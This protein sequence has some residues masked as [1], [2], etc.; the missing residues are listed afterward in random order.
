MSKKKSS[1][2]RWDKTYLWHPFTQQ[3]DWEKDDPLI[4]QSA[5]GSYLTD[6]EGR[7]YLDGV[8][9]LWVTVHGHR[10][11]A[12]DRAVKSQLAR[13]A[14]TTFLGLTHEPAILLAK[15]LVR[16]APRGLRRV[17][18]SDN[19][20]TAVEVAL[21]MAYQYG[22]QQTSP[23]RTEFL[24]LKNSYHGDTLGSVS[25]GGIDLFHKA[26]KP[27]LFRAR[28]AISPHCYRCPYRRERG[29]GSS[30]IGNAGG[31]ISAPKP[32]DSRKETGCRWECLRSAEVVFQSRRGR[33]AAAVIE[34]SVQG[35]AG[36][37]VMP[38]GYMKG[39]EALCRREGVPLICDEVA[40]GFGRTGAMF[41]VDHEGVSPDIMCV[42]KSITGGY[43]PL[44]ATL[45]TERIYQAFLGRYEEFKTFYHGHTYTAN[46]LACA[47]A[48][49]NLELYRTQRLLRD[50]GRKAGWLAQALDGLRSLP[51]VG[52]VRQIGF[53]AG[54]ELVQ[55]PGTRR[56]FPPAWKIGQKVCLAARERGL[57]LRPLGDV[58]VILPPLG[59]A[60]GDL[61]RLFRGVREAILETAYSLSKEDGRLP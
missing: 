4:I 41:A 22:R 50:V 26:F 61:R 17:F 46:P 10:H 15:E 30:R 33:L 12:L 16:I 31:N 23:L 24:A 35:A 20:S 39:F 5:R 57:W 3:A 6:V 29:G 11:P 52:D 53:M 38:R 47:A 37:I 60:D 8:S 49:A 25:I 9:S 45:T 58:I 28:F 48:L 54:V 55:D 1:L 21:K 42:A 44:A 19:G 7:R 43:L 27:L 36:M 2:A 56:P 51:I 14:H 13:M 18:Y 32:G 59:I 34:P 40:T